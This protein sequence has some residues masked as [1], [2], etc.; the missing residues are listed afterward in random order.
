MH[1]TLQNLLVKSNL[2]ALTLTNP[3][4]VVIQI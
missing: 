2:T 3:I 1:C 4:L